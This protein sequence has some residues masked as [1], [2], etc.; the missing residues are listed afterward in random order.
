[1]VSKVPHNWPTSLTS[2][3]SRTAPSFTH[4]NHSSGVFTTF[5]LCSTYPT[6]RYVLPCLLTCA[7]GEVSLPS[8]LIS[9]VTPSGVFHPPWRFALTCLD[10]RCSPPCLPHSSPTANRTGEGTGERIS[11]F[12]WRHPK[13]VSSLCSHPIGQNLGTAT[14][15]FKGDWEMQL[16]PGLPCAS[17]EV[18]VGHCIIVRGKARMNL[19]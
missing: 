12:V 18:E 9:N 13:L 10:P 16:Y 14:Y 15:D 11:A 8:R 17:L 1:M 7:S 4:P 2:P 5:H 3:G 19:R 6:A